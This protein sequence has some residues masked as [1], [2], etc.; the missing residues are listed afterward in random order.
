[1]GILNSWVA[2]PPFFIERY[3]IRSELK[4]LTTFITNYFGSEVDRIVLFGSYLNLLQFNFR[5]D[6]DIA[7]I[8][9]DSE[10]W[11]LIDSNTLKF[12]D[13]VPDCRINFYST[14]IELCK[15]LTRG[16]DIKI[17]TKKDLD[18]I[19]KRDRY[20]PGPRGGNFATDIARGKTIF[21]NRGAH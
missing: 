5:S 13:E 14:L 11:H 8:L 10:K 12:R 9:L 6:I 21:K 20:M 1:M 16:Y 18:L 17:Y 19:Y 7:V 4:R 2:M 3:K 15:T